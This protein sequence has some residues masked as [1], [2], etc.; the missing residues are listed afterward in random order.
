MSDLAFILLTGAKL[1][2]FNLGEKKKVPL[3]KSQLFFIATQV[4]ADKWVHW[5]HT[6]QKAQ[7][8]MR[9]GLNPDD[10]DY[11]NNNRAL[12]PVYN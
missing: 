6:A 11:I 4:P 9:S 10:A 8:P 7:T 2:A 3:K 12:V 1:F 5:L